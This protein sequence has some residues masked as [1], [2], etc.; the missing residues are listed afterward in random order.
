MDVADERLVT[1]VGQFQG[2]DLARTTAV[3]VGDALFEGGG[4]LFLLGR[5]YFLMPVHQRV[6]QRLALL[7]EDAG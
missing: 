5:Q 7:T 4:A 3:D 6:Q 2:S 1:V